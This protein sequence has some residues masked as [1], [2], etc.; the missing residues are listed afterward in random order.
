MTYRERVLNTFAFKPV[1]RNPVSVMEGNVWP[2]LMEYFT[3]K[4][5][6]KDKEEVFNYLNDDFRWFL[7]GTREQL[8]HHTADADASLESGT[9]SDGEG[10]LLAGAKTPDDVKRL[11]NPDAS[12]VI[13][14]DFKLARETWPDHALI[15][16]PVWMPIFSGACEAFGMEEA[17]VT[18][19]TEPKLFTA[20]AEQQTNHAIEVFRKGFEFGANKYF[21]FAWIGD[22]FASELAPIIS[23]ELWRKLVKPHLTKIIDFIKKSG[24]KVL[25][26]SCGAVRDFIPDFT[27]MGIDGLLIVQTTAK[28]MEID[29]LARDFGGKIVF[30]GGMD[31]QWLLTQGTPQQVADEA[32]SNC[33][34][35]EKC[36][37]Y[38]VSNCHTCMPDVKGENIEAMCKAI[39][40]PA[41][42]NCSP[43]HPGLVKF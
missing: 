35:F 28:G 8:G 17:M 13:Y 36:G 4:H 38:V 26:H 34:A 42:A 15:F 22:D 21:D 11:Y 29:G 41:D 3:N 18:M 43:M 31:V 19:L 23:P 20:Y 7:A 24:M 5:G 39:S 32:I 6:F 37:G 12:L 40:E 16:I 9:Y 14:P 25:F 33:R 10:R 30:F 2:S 1:D 27:E